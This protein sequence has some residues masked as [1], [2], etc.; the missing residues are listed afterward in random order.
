MLSQSYLRV[1][2]KELNGSAY[3]RRVQE[4]AAVRAGLGEGII[5]GGKPQVIAAHQ[6]LLTPNQVVIRC[7]VVYLTGLLREA[8]YL[9][10]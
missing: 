9:L 6:I 5:V 1:E 2:V 8:N 4:I 7:D 3:Q 10:N